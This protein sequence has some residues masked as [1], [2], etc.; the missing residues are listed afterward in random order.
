MAVAATV[1]T[2]G[3]VQL[4]ISI[5]DIALIFEQ[6]RKVGNWF[7]TR[8][9]DQT[10]F[11]ILGE[12]PE[13]LLKRRGIVEPRDITRRFPDV[14]FIYHEGKVS[15]QGK[16]FKP[17]NGQANTSSR[18]KGQLPVAANT[19]QGSDE[20]GPFSWLM[21]MIVTA[22]DICLPTQRVL[23]VLVSVFTR[24]LDNTDVQG[25]QEE[26]SE[27]AL[28]TTLGTNIESWRSVGQ[29]RRV[30][31][32]LRR[33]YHRMWRNKTGVEHA[34]AQLNWAE[35]I[36]VRRFLRVLFED[37][38]DHFPCES[39]STIA[40]AYAIQRGGVSIQAS[41]ADRINEAQLLVE[42]TDAQH[43]SRLHHPLGGLVQ[44]KDRLQDRSQMISYPRGHPESMIQAIPRGLG[45]RNE[46]GKFWA[47]GFDGASKYC[48]IAEADLP[49]DKSKSEVYSKGWF[50]SRPST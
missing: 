13:S 16:T 5:S 12:D 45:T 44:A 22:L 40:L 7:F 14:E 27:T 8:N 1:G 28:Q 46:L 6:G 21:V 36:E 33:E 25:D 48:L 26:N 47:L 4:G 9:H 30:D 23:S 18:K 43:V 42:Y 2:Q 32:L 50:Q 17:S 37:K 19:A 10:L 11:E 35:E 24:V 29:V 34:F 20:L 41:G 15:T 38:E 3:L 31:Q 49:Y 39:A